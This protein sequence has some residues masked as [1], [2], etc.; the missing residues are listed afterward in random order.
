[1]SKRL[2][3]LLTR[4][5]CPLHEFDDYDINILQLREQSHTRLP[6]KVWSDGNVPRL[7]GEVAKVWGLRPDRRHSSVLSPKPQD[8]PIIKRPRGKPHYQS[9]GIM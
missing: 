9:N 2:N 3:R 8:V 4:S 1:M 7:Q 6:R 5:G